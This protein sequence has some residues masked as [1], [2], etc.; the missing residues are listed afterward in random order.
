[1]KLHKEGNYWYYDHQWGT[2][3]LRGSTGHTDKY[4]ARLWAE[5]KVKEVELKGVHIK[6][7][8]F[9]AFIKRYWQHADARDK[10]DTIVVKRV[11]LNHFMDWRT[12]PSVSMI[13]VEDVESWQS[14]M[15]KE[16]K[17]KPVTV[18]SYLLTLRIIFNVALRWG[19]MEK[20]PFVLAPLLNVKKRDNRAFSKEEIESVL[21]KT[22][23]HYPRYYDLFYFYL[24]TGMRRAEPM[25][26]EWKDIDFKGKMIM[27]DPELV[28]THRHIV[29]LPMTEEILK[30]R[31]AAGEK[32]PFDI[33][34]DKAGENFIKVRKLAGVE[35]ASIKTFRRSTTSYLRSIGI[36]SVIVNY[37]MGHSEET[38]L[39]HYFFLQSSEL[40]NQIGRLQDILPQYNPVDKETN[41]RITAESIRLGIARAKANKK[42]LNPVEIEGF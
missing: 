1:M 14:Y 22:R 15:V 13:T 17:I 16:K 36:P 2:K 27:L 18:N 39:N 3:R 4:K 20:N 28:K 12:F 32:K 25:T 38:A 9:G 33:Y 21:T 40:V 26:L 41:D 10:R 31:K 7:N 30:E 34:P 37:I 35:W 24:L 29:I 5:A 11:S 8:D 6:D 19:Y 23:E 42:P